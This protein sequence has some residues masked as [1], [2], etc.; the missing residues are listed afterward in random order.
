MSAVRQYASSPA[1]VSALLD[2]LPRT[3]RLTSNSQ[4]IEHV[5][6]TSLPSVRDPAWQREARRALLETLLAAISTHGPMARID[7]LAAI[8]A[9]S[10]QAAA[11]SIPPVDATAE[12]HAPAGDLA[13][14]LWRTW[15]SAAEPL[16]PS[17]SPPMPLSEIDRRRAG[18]LAH[19]RGPVQVFAAQQVSIAEV[20]AYIITCERP[21]RADALRDTITELASAR[22]TATHIFDQM[23]AAERAILHLWLIRIEEEEAL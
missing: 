13:E 15:R 14:Q 10:Y 1:V 16:V 18:R 17:V 12:L 21:G 22:R 9:H 6:A 4:L 7:Q 20:M 11:A 19:A 2:R 8:L 5:S 3:P 23:T